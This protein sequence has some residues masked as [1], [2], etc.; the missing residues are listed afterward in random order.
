MMQQDIETTTHFQQ[1]ETDIKSETDINDEEIQE[2]LDTLLSKY[3]NQNQAANNKDNIVFSSSSLSQVEASQTLE[4]V[5]ENEIPMLTEI[6]ILQ[7][8]PLR[9]ILDAALEKT[10]IE[11]N[12]KDRE[13]LARA[14]AN[15]LQESPIDFIQKTSG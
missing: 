15:Q 9:S 13:E 5:I 7:S 3:Q 11:M 2:K 14:L 8:S 6:V 10:R 4:E 12:I 1:S